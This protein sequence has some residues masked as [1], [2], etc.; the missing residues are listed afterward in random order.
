MLEMAVLKSARP[1]APP[2][3][4]YCGTYFV[5]R[6]ISQGYAGRLKVGTRSLSLEGEELG[7]NVLSQDFA[8]AR[9]DK[10]KSSLFSCL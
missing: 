8:Q 3:F 2:T 9:A 7:S 6:S 1:E 5:S 10:P 4:V